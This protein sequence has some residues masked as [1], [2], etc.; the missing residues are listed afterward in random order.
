MNLQGYQVLHDDK[1]ELFTFLS[2]GPRGSI[3]K[4]IVYDKIGPKSYNLGFG[5]WDHDKMA[6]DD[7][8]RSNNGD[9]E[10]V[11]TTVAL[12]VINFLNHHPDSKVFVRGST[13]SRTRLYQMGINSNW[14]E[15]SQLLELE[16]YL[17]GD[18]KSFKPSVNYEAFVIRNKKM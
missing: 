9:R 2:N 14:Q 4:F 3:E 10:Q 5:D 6:I 12:T 8:A 18:W 17:N 11:L 13:A 15:I 1:H 7:T 16:G